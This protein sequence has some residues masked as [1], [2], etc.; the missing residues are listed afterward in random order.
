[1]KR[2]ATR[3]VLGLLLLLVAAFLFRRPPREET[4]Q[5]TPRPKPPAEAPLPREAP[6]L[7]PLAPTAAVAADVRAPVRLAGPGPRGTIR[8]LVRIKGPIPS[9]K[10]VKFDADPACAALHEGSVKFMDDLVADANGNVQWAFVYV[11][12]GPIGAPP[13][14]PETPVLMDQIN[15]FFIPHVVGIRVGQPLRVLSS[16]PLLHVVHAT[17]VNNKETNVGLPQAGMHV[18]R[19]FEAQ[20]VMVR[21][22]CDIHPWMRAWIG[23]MDH[24]H[25]AVTNELGSYTIPDLPPGRYSIETWH[26]RCNPAVMSVDVPPGGNTQLDFVLDLKYR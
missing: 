21:I 5:R 23:V 7:A 24:P 10:R 26:E 6:A 16:D 20:E 15:C 1:M 18:E 25:F 13:P 17:A 3:M 14:P 8:G 11:R 2:A 4:P 19:T 22:Q 9:R 12:S